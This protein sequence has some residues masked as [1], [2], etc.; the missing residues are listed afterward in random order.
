M[1]QLAL[2]ASG[3]LVLQ[4]VPAV[5]IAKSPLAA[6]LVMVNADDPLLVS[7]AVCAALV[8]PTA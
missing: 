7:V 5:A 6:M 8:A 3:L 2:A 4:V 1:V